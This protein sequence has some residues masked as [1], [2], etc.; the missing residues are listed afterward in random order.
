[1]PVASVDEFDLDV[2][3]LITAMVGVQYSRQRWQ[4]SCTEEFIRTARSRIV[5]SVAPLNQQ[6][7]L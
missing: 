7:P 5:V 3:V 2:M 1:M 4:H 6:Y